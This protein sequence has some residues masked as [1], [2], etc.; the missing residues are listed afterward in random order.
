[1]E[2]T[3]T[4]VDITDG[5]HRVHITA[6]IRLPETQPQEVPSPVVE[7]DAPAEDTTDRHK[8]SEVLS[9]SRCVGGDAASGILE[10][11]T[12]YNLLAYEQAGAVADNAP[13][14]T[15]SA[16]DTTQPAASTTPPTTLTFG[17]V[18]IGVDGDMLF[19]TDMWK[20]AGAVNSKK[21]YEWLRQ[22]GTKAF[23]SSIWKLRAWHVV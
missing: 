21:P 13:K 14:L 9:S 11:N 16:A 15:A 8:E 4:G 2:I 17:G 12:H 7:P 18:T 22:D 20:A 19:L 5:V 3:V 23:I 6:A 10:G 1:M